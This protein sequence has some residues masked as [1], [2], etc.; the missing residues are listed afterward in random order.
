MVACVH[1]FIATW[2]HFLYFADDWR[3]DQ[4]R[5]YNSGVRS[6]PKKNPKVKKSYFQ[7]HTPEG[8]SNEFVKHAYQLLTDSTKGAVLI[9]YMGDETC[10]IEFA[11][12]NASKEQSR[13]YNRI[14]PSVIQSMKDSC[15]SDTPATVYREHITKVP[16]ATHLAVLQP[17]NTRQVK[18]IRSA[19]QRQQRLSHDGLYNL[20]E[21]A[22]DLPDFVHSIRTHPDLVCV[23]G[24]KQLFNEL[25]RV[26]V[27][28]YGGHQL[29]S[30]DTT[31]QLGD[32][33]VSVLS[34]RHTIFQEDPVIP[35]AFLLH[36]RKLAL[37]HIEFFE[38]CCKLIPALKTTRK[39]IVTDEE[40]AY[41]EAIS[42]CMPGA[43]HLRC[44][45]HVIQAAERWLRDHLPK[46]K[47][48]DVAVYRNDLKEL[49]HLS[50]KEE[51][52]K[53]LSSL[54]GKWSAPFFD[55][56]N[57][58]IHPDIESLPRWAIE[59]YGVYCP[60][61]GI[62]NNQA[63]GINFVLKQ[64]RKWKEAPID[65]MILSLH[66]LQGFYI[67][68]IARGQQNLGNYHLRPEFS[69]HL[70]MPLSL[71]DGIVYSPE[72]IVSRMKENTFCAPDSIS[73]ATV[74]PDDEDVSDEAVV[75]DSTSQCLSQ[76]QRAKR[77]IEDN[78]IS[79][80]SK[81]HTF[82]V[83]GS[84]C[85]HVVTLHPKETC[86]CPSTTECYHIMAAKMAI[87]KQEDV[88]RK[89]L[90]LAQLRKNSR[91][92]NSKKSGR[93]RPRPGDCDIIP[94]PDAVKQLK[95]EAG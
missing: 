79:F 65:C 51:Y 84:T 10:A 77:V 95:S 69:D 26:L 3:S 1:D 27:L 25:D 85:P 32:F 64:L 49:L 66:Y 47:G 24:N 31:F 40:Q 57:C 45:N 21:L 9:H 89:T 80:D 44:W 38:V 94:A 46:G 29:L 48:D 83:M 78:K 86:S 12:G 56:F 2:N 62:T 6:L 68:E 74:L 53:Q 15:K 20:H 87:G 90:S 67:S 93:K 23:C 33:Y 54:S 43:P 18:N 61:G 91:P 4:Y 50:S 71:P 36:E 11:H 58:N 34:F 16:P 35:I 72:E 88:K 59:P 70:A 92:R 52:T 13:P 28:K 73:Q 19:L 60:F 37:H 14:C 63:E 42:K 41:V 8:P 17:R 5:W 55:Y 22:F 81:L 30:Y 7:L 39:P 82:T 75:T 76:T